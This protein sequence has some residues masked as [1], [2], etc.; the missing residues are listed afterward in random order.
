[1]KRLY[2]RR[3]KKS[4]QDARIPAS[5]ENS[6]RI[7]TLFPNIT[8]HDYFGVFAH[9]SNIYGRKVR[10]TLEPLR[11]SLS[12]LDPNTSGILVLDA[13]S[14]A[15]RFIFSMYCKCR[16]SLRVVVIPNES[17][18]ALAPDP[19][20]LVAVWDLILQE[21][22]LRNLCSW[23]AEVYGEI[24]AGSGSLGARVRV[25]F[26]EAH[27]IGQVCSNMRDRFPWVVLM[28]DQRSSIIACETLLNDNARELLEY[29]AAYSESD[30]LMRECSERAERLSKII[31]D[32]FNPQERECIRVD[33][34]FVMFA[35]GYRPTRDFDIYVMNPFG[36]RFA[37]KVSRIF[38]D[39]T[40]MAGLSVDVAMVGVRYLD[41]CEEW[42]RVYPTLISAKGLDHL[43][44]MPQ[45]ITF[46]K[47]I[48][49]VT[50]RTLLAERIDR[51]ERWA[52]LGGLV[53]VLAIRMRLGDS[54]PLPRI[55]SFVSLRD[56]R[57]VS[58]GFDRLRD[59]I[60]QLFRQ[61]Y[62]FELSDSAVERLSEQ[63]W[64]Y[65][66]Q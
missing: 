46:F 24:P 37:E 62:H 56:G 47:G 5:A 17:S 29:S 34:G 38:S 14:S 20:K 18:F 15:A 7:V 19:G 54:I 65:R 48:K 10:G 32:N 25:L 8:E 57:R 42:L 2:P 45:H 11:Q 3:H 36:T 13:V 44:F 40:I 30:N 52:V 53:D 50:L 16:S 60:K 61:K 63:V 58:L 9:I 41:E 26:I 39:K 27:D 31:F 64:K 51:V 23:G 33:S 35:Y 28:A 4:T 66:R 22:G 21:H 6:T 59:S 43:N 1:V 55:N 12:E 49:L